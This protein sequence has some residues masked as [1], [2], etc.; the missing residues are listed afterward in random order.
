M[1]RRSLVV[2][3]YGDL[4]QKIRCAEEPD[5]PMLIRQ[6]LDMQAHLPKCSLAARRNH[7]LSQFQL[8]IETMADEC[9]PPQWRCQCLDHIHVPL[10]ALARLADCQRSKRQVRALTH[11]LRV[12]SHYLQPGLMA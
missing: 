8:L 7:F 9:L 10:L 4:S 11:E 2:S 1:K 5:N 6:Y 12:I 3:T